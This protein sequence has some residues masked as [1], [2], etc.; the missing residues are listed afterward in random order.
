VP[1]PHFQRLAGLPPYVL[2]AVDDKKDEL[3]A[4]GEDVYDFGLGNPDRPSPPEVVEA[5]RRAALDGRNHRYQPSRGTAA[6]RQ[7]IARWYR[8]RYDVALDP[9]TETVATIGSKEGLGH[10]ALAVLGPG[11][12]V[13]A[14]D[15][16]Y[17]VHRFGPQFAGATAVPVATGP[18]RD[19]LAELEA[20]YAA[21]PSRPK[22]AIVN[23]PHN[24]TSATASAE[25]LAAIVRWAE[26]RDL[27]LVSDL[28]YADL[29]F[30]V[31]RAPS[32]LAVPGARERTVEFFTLSKSYNMAGWRV[33][34]CVGNAKLVGA[35]A[36]IKGYLDY[37][38]FGAVQ[39]AAAE[40]LD[41]GDPVAEAVRET[42]RARAQALVA[43]LGRAGW[44][45]EAPRAT[46]FVWAPVP[47]RF[48]HLG[49]VGFAVKLI[50]EARVAVAPGV[51]FGPG[52]EGFVRFSLV[53]DVERIERATAAIGRALSR[54]G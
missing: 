43:G 36:R 33:G 27:W 49:S 17:P 18:G 14:P 13:L 35:L 28:A 15:P 3:R 53:E 12:V 37:G 21:A 26:R 1:D 52:G 5:L 30:D 20:A 23:F 25:T 45:V 10:L 40:V 47:A 32:A 54:A 41:Q 48:A 38:I 34:F 22:L 16:C 39:Q 6:L 9:E 42:Y 44:P 11:D 46:M 24:P 8:R 31:A 50:D 29:C 7:A 51:G 4:R 19:P 2:G